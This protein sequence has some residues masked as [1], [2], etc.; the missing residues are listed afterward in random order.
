[1]PEINV[2]LDKEKMANLGLNVFNV[3]ATM[4]TAFGG[5]DASSYTDNGVEY[6]IVV[7]LQKFDRRNAEDV[8]SL[9]FVNN[10]EN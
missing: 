4:A 5:N 9:S 1:M 2:S 10:Q 6:D 7:Q 3:R 8:G